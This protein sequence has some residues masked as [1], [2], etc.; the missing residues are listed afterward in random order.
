MRELYGQFGLHPLTI[1]V[2]EDGNTV[3]AL[4][5]RLSSTTYT[6]VSFGFFDTTSAKCVTQLRDPLDIEASPNGWHWMNDQISPETQG[7]NAYIR[8]VTNLEKEKPQL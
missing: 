8:I 1:H 2:I 4:A 7:P 3:L 5:N 6:A